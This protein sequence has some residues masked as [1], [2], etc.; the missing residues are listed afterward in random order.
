M[1]EE[2]ELIQELERLHIR[3]AEIIS[4]LHQKRSNQKSPRRDTNLKPGDKV[5]LLTKGVL[6][7]KGDLAQITRINGDTVHLKIL[8]NDH[9]THRKIKNVRRAE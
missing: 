5:Q 9:H 6:S 2:E 3:Q 1:D 7:A 8:K 4:K